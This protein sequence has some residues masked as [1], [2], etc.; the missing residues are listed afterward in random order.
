[1]IKLRNISKSYQRPGEGVLKV[2]NEVDFEVTRGEFVAI[3]GPSGSGKS[4]LMN[5]LGLLD[6]PDSGA[7][8]LAGTEVSS[9]SPTELA[10]TRNNTIGFVFQQFHLLPRTTATENVELPLVY[11]DKVFTDTRK[12]AIDALCRVGLEERL[13]H[14]PNELSGGQ[15]QRVAIARALAQGGKVLVMDEPLVNLDYKLREELELQLRDL[16]SSGELVVVYSTSDPKDAFKLGDQVLLLDDYQ[17]LQSGSPLDVYRDPE[18]LESADLMSDPGV[19]VIDA[20]SALRPE[21]I[22]LERRS[23]TDLAFD[24][25]LVGIE[26]NGSET[27]LHCRRDAHIWVA[28]LAGMVHMQLGTMLPLFAHVGDVLRFGEVDGEN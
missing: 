27:F 15:Q 8:E 24:G 20:N 11:S 14:Y 10:R 13:T 7:Y 23:P 9:L 21:H 3:V 2:L 28:K 25:E 26:T 6:K 19:N 17:V 22:T 16:L 18:S 5:I 12:K 4:T 1:M